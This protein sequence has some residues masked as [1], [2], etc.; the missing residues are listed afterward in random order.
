MRVVDREQTGVDHRLGVAVAGQRLGGRADGRGQGV[1]HLGLTHIFRTGDDVADLTGTECLGTGHIGADHADFNGIVGHANAHHVD[2]FAVV[3]F[4]VLHTDVGDDAAVGVVDGI[5]D[6]RAGGGI[7]VAVRGGHVHDDL[8][9][10]VGHAFAGFAG[11]AQHVARLAADQTCDLLGMLVRFCGRQVDFVEHGDDGQ[12]MVDGHIQ[13]GQG[14][15]LDALGGVDE[16]HRAFAGGQCAGHLIGEVH[17]AGGVDH[18]ER[19]FGAVKGP[20]HAH[21]LG[22]DGDA[23]LLLDIHT[24]EEA[25]AHLSL[26]HNAAQLQ[27]AVGHGRLAV[28]DVCDDTEVANHRLIRGTRLIVLDDQRIPPL[29]IYSNFT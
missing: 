21:G 16:Q 3:Q 10:Q 14:L 5:E 9:E 1:A 22:F 23:T 8:V 2:L 7:G 6:Q 12:I 19:V 25:I 13:I 24:V 26:W 15:R 11:D 4:A 20:R 17:V 29:G 27:D 18:T 28:V